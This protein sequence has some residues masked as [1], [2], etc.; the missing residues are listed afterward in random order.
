MM[1]RPRM[2]RPM[3]YRPMMVRNNPHHKGHTS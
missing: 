1:Y 3:M 2:Y